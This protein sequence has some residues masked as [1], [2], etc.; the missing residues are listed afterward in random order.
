MFGF[1][2]GFVGLDEHSCALALHSDGG[3][4]VENVPSLSEVTVSP[5]LQK[6][7]TSQTRGNLGAR[8]Q[9]SKRKNKT[10]VDWVQKS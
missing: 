10:N 5:D 3:V 4:V 7:L 1:V 9:K 8:T 6:G 2:D